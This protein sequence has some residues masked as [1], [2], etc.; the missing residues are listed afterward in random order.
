MN[1]AKI[2]LIGIG[3]QKAATSWLFRCLKEHPEVRGAVAEE[4][5]GKEVNFFN[6]RFERGYSWYHGLFEFGDWVNAEFSV[7][8]FHDSDVPA[9]MKEYNP[10]ARLLLSLRN[11]VDRAWSHHRHEVRH[12]RL[13]PDL[14]KFSDARDLNPSYLSIGLYA[15]H[16]ERWLEHFPAQ[17]I[18]VTLHDEL[19]LDPIEVI[20]SVYDFA[21]VAK[22]HEPRSLREE[23]N[24]AVGNRRPGLDLAMKK[25]SRSA[26]SILGN[27]PVELAKAT[28]IPDR[29]RARNKVL[30][31]EEIVPPLD[32]AERAG[33]VDY[34]AEQIQGLSLLINKDL[35]HW[36]K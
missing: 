2:G 1:S 33:L 29:V 27:W 4:V 12:G 32:R 16:L 7:L 3:V 28:G 13:P 17:Q 6:H 20:R 26:R 14:W 8:Y 21:G 9:R 19:R 30:I 23:V 5:N 35:D 31:G 34:Y 11:P 15:T 24:V 25:I 10:E 18:H 36:L 22:D